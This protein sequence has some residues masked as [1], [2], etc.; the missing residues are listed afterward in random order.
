LLQTA[1]PAFEPIA[2]ERAQQARFVEQVKRLARHVAHRQAL[3]FGRQALEREHH[4]ADAGPVDRVGPRHVDDDV[5]RCIG[6]LL[7]VVAH[8]FDALGVETRR[9]AEEDRHG[10]VPTQ[11]L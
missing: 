5:V 7:E 9:G 1:A 3:A 2:G 11:E 6:Q 4:R 10:G 8:G